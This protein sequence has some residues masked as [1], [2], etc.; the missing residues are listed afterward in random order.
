YNN[1]SGLDSTGASSIVRF[2]KKL[3]DE[4]GLA[5]LCTIHQP[6]A[7]LFEDF[8]DVLL[9][10]TGG[11]EVYFGPIGDNGTTIIEYFERNGAPKAAPDANPA[12]YI[13]EVGSPPQ[14]TS[15]SDG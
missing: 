14:V 8:D 5:I 7:I 13:L 6:S 4:A 15:P 12:E 3:A 1:R 2:L 10:T 11:E 9:L